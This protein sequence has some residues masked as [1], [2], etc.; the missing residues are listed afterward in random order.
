MKMRLS[1]Y[2]QKQILEIL[3]SGIRGYRKICRIDDKGGRKINRKRD[4][5]ATDR[6]IT[7]AL[8]KTNWYKNRRK[9]AQ[10]VNGEQRRYSGGAP[11]VREV[12]QCSKHAKGAKVDIRETKAVVLDAGE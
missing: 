6:R 7:K 5:G 9:F 10:T 8:G 1:G 11:V 3:L 2:N 12:K 4:E